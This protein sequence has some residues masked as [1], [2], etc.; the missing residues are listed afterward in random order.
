MFVGIKQI[1]TV[2]YY[3]ITETKQKEWHSSLK[4][5]VRNPKLIV[6]SLIGTGLTDPGS[7]LGF[8]SPDP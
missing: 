4:R 2:K 8:W 7:S 5:C 1:I 3:W 6:L